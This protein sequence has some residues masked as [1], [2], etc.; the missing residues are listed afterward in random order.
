MNR[1]LTTIALA[2][3]LAA[4]LSAGAATAGHHEAEKPK[5]EHHD[6]GKH[7]GH[8]KRPEHAKGEDEAGHDGHGEHHDHGKKPKADDTKK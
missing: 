5:T 6:H 8:K 3:F 4:F 2:V 7:E 1:K